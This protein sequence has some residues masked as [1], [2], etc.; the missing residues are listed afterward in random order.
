[1]VSQVTACRKEEKEMLINAPD[2]HFFLQLLAAVWL[3]KM[4]DS[5]VSL[6][7]EPL[8]GRTTLLLN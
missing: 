7:C 1:M 6:P 4:N 5:D 2:L 3:R 8:P